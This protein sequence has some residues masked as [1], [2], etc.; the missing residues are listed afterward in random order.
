MWIS[1]RWLARHVDL[2]GVD[3]HDLGNRFTLAVAELEGV[4]QVGALEGVVVAHVLS[5]EPVEGTKLRLC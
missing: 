4:H 3:L 2:E 5:A 1:C